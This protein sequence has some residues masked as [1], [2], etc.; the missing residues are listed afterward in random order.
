[1]VGTGKVALAQELVHQDLSHAV[2]D[3]VHLRGCRD[4]YN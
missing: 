2:A 3:A 1:V 4:N